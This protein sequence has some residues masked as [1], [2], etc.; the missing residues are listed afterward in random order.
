MCQGD[1]SL[2]KTWECANLLRFGERDML[3]VSSTLPRVSYA[4]GTF[5]EYRFHPEEWLAL[6][7]GNTLYAT[8]TFVNEQGDYVLVGWL[9]VRGNGHWNGCL[10]LP[11]RMVLDDSNQVQI[12]PVKALERLRG[13]HTHFGGSVSSGESRTGENL[14][15]IR[16][17]CLEIVARFR[18]SAGAKVGFTLQDDDLARVILFDSATNR[19]RCIDDRSTLERVDSS[20]ELCFH[21]FLDHSVVEVFIN[22]REASTSWFRPLLRGGRELRIRP[23]LDGEAIDYEIDVWKLAEDGVVDAGVWDLQRDSAVE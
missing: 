22:Y 14:P 23:I 1:R 6:D 17:N 13:D 12:T 11:R 3:V 7:H 2:G 9:R 10:S 21:L 16:G 15:E 18:L 5:S 4:L 20:E 8:N 19:M